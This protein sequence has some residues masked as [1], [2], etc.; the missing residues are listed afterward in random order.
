MNLS[1]AAR[2]VMVAAA[3]GVGLGASVDPAYAQKPA[4]AEPDSKPKKVGVYVEGFQAGKIRQD[5]LATLP[6]D[7][8]VANDFAFKSALIKSG[9]QLPMGGVLAIEDAREAS[10]P[11]IRAALEKI[12]ADGAILGLIRKRAGG[13]GVEVYLVYVPVEEGILPVDGATPITLKDDKEAI[14]AA[15]VPAFAMLNP[16]EEP[17]PEEEEPEEEPKE[18]E[19][20]EEE[21]P[22]EPEEE[23]GPDRKTGA[24]GA[25]LFSIALAFELGGRFFSYNDGL[26]SNLRDYD[27]FGVPSLFVGAEVY[28]L[29]DT[30]TPIAQDLGIVGHF[31]QAFALDSET[32]DG[33]V[34]GTSWNRFDVG[35]RFRLSLGD[36]GDAPVLGLTGGFARHDFSFD[37]EGPLAEEV[38]SVTYSSLFIG[39]DGRIPAGPV[40]I[41]AAGKYLGALSAGA[42]KDRF[43]DQGGAA[44]RPTS[45]GGV[46]FAGGVAI[47]IAYGFEGRV[48]AE[49]QRWFYSFEPEVGDPNIAGGALD[50]YLFLQLGAGFLY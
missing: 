12:D 9:R 10:I 30:G 13:G 7:V 4:E 44:E 49:Y 28:P 31:G 48:M 26:S 33:T 19:P 39:L 18:D 43:T 20:K 27:V 24:Y 47:P 2:V 5:I 32:S 40:A 1:R 50:Q 45:V 17:E 36:R 21:Q 8:E 42:T 35:L 14:G 22:E 29:T 15:L 38:P 41:M 46:S 23:A 25:E 37:A 6:D 11:R 16:P 34:V 3:V